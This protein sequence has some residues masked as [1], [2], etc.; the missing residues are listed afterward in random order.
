M[1]NFGLIIV[2]VQV[3]S[4][5][6]QAQKFVNEF[7][8]IGVGARAHGM[9]GSVV[10]SANDGTAAYWNTAGLTDITSPLQINAMHA[11]WFGGIA[12]YDYVSIA[13]KLNSD[14]KSVA[15]F[16]FIRL[17]VDNIPNT[18]NLIGPDGT[19]DINKVTN[20]SAS[21]YAGLFSYARTIG[22]DERLSVGGN[23]KVI[24]RSIG[25][26]GKAWGFG[27]DLGVK[28]KGDNFSLGATARDITTTFNAWSFNLTD[29]EKRVFQ[30]TGND[31][32]V[33]SS[34]ITLPRLILGGA[35]FG[36]R[37]NFSYLAEV[38][39][40]L[41]TNG[42]QS[43][44]LSGNNLN[45]D[46]SLGV[47]LGYMQKVYLRM[48]LGNMQTVINQTNTSQ[49]DF[50]IQPNVGLGLKLGRLKVDYALANI[51]SVSGVLVSHIFSLGL[52][53]VPRK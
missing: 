6:T 29:E 35:Y 47:E 1:K 13:K 26:F 32:P 48:G 19:V 24:H 16:S 11:K 28:Y 33:S 2:F 27:A 25:S 34:E 30:S 42:T 40:N 45:L 21:D 5:S 23:I 46:P 50:E 12:N 52:D 18:L 9:F 20:F 4:F 15:S 51:G 39:F 38:D 49:R 8:N 43:G 44:I 36:N 53:F 7:L 14:Y 41:S 17:G 31:I 3:F 22:N 10:A 37:G